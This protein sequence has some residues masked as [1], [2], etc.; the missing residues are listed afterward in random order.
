MPN[1]N[2]KEHD[3]LVLEEPSVKN[4]TMAVVR[5]E[6]EE[7]AAAIKEGKL[8][9]RINTSKMKGETKEIL[10]NVNG[11][12]E[13]LLAPF[14][15]TAEYI[16]RISK[17]DIPEKITEKYS[18]D[19]NEIKN[20]INQLITVLNGLIA[21]AAT[22]AEAAAVGNL[23]KRADINKYQGAWQTIVKGLND[24]AEN[25]AV[26]LKDIGGVLDRLSAGDSKAQVTADYKGAYNVLKIAANNLGNQINMVVQEMEKLAAAA[27]QGNMDYRG[28]SSKVKGDIAEIIN[29]ANRTMEGVAVPLKD[30]CGILNQ[31]A[32]GETKARCINDYKGLYNTLKVACNE[33]A[34]QL[35]YLILDD[36]GVTLQ[37]AADKNLKKRLQRTYKGDFER[38]KQ[39][40]NTVLES[41]DQALSQVAEATVQVASASQQIASG[42]QS[43]AQGANEQASSIEEISS[44]L[45]EM[46]SM[47]KQNADNAAQAKALADE[48]NKNAENGAELMKKM[49]ESMQTIKESSN[50]TAKIVK[51]IDE[52]AMQTNLLALNAAVEAARA[53]EAGRGFAVV[54]EEVRN[55]AQRSAEA[56]KNTADMIQESVNNSNKGAQIA[57]DAGKAIEAIRISNKKV[58]DLIAEIAAAS[59]EQAKGIDQINIAVSQLDKVTQQNAANSEESAS[60]AEELSSQAEE[61]Q[62]MVDQFE[63]T[64]VSQKQSVKTGSVLHHHVTT[65]TQ[66]KKPQKTTDITK[67]K[68]NVASSPEKVIPMDDEKLAQF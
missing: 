50:Q 62:S 37:A 2:V 22:M 4:S 41:L 33:L 66:L 8:D 48:A 3:T 65:N 25:M 1:V 38:M 49:L 26:P 35:Q 13:A 40:I 51:T 7:I 47:T 52:I 32:A 29:G 23:D 63:I 5:Q 39:N 30:I 53:G 57:E 68:T 55:L 34:E 64:A 61:L 60:A 19:F 24:T 11:V 46:T 36:G 44:S 20:N 67:K 42:A 17:G 31:L 43:L 56:A 45:E 27:A 14:N 21:E 54:A 58:N 9:R 15:V 16:D 10:D 6:I 18:G 12:I 28:D 59:T